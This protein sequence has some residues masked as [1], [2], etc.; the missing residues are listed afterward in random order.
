MPT[1]S[2]T[3]RSAPARQSRFSR[4]TPTPPA[5]A[6]FGRSQPQPSRSPFKRTAKRAAKGGIAA[7]MLAK[8]PKGK[9]LL[10]LGGLAAGA[11]AAKKQRDDKRRNEVPPVPPTPVV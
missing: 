11:A 9:S 1:T 7:T 10:A 4:G 8:I 2:R 6:R 3:H 5:R